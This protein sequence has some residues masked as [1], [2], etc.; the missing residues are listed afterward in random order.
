MANVPA[1]AA[2][3]ANMASPSAD[4]DRPTSLPTLAAAAIA[5][6]DAV[7]LP[8]YPEYD[9]VAAEIL[10]PVAS[11]L[12]KLAE[13]TANFMPPPGLK[14]KSQ[15]QLVS[16]RLLPIGEFVVRHIS[17]LEEKQRGNVDMRLW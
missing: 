14:A 10:L 5:T 13:T 1:K 12:K 4:P 6:A 11:Q 16:E 7:T 9:T 3:T 8:S 2:N 15:V 17:T